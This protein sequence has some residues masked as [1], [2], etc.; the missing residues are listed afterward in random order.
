MTGVAEPTKQNDTKLEQKQH[1]NNSMFD[2]EH[3]KSSEKGMVAVGWS[4]MWRSAARV[5]IRRGH[6]TY[7]ELDLS[8]GKLGELSYLHCPFP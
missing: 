8:C 5:M 4:L 1:L 6:P 7:Q 2:T 3:S